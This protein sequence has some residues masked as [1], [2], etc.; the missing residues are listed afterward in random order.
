MPSFC[1]SLML[2]KLLEPVPIDIV[3]Q[4]KAATNGQR[5]HLIILTLRWMKLTILVDF[6]FNDL[7]LDIYGRY[8]NDNFIPW[9][10]GVDNLLL[11]KQALDEHIR[12]I[13]PNINF[14]RIS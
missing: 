9:L 7:E 8:R 4:S 6:S 3:L 5:M 13:Y 12:S 2:L 1:V 11:F 10:D 14:I